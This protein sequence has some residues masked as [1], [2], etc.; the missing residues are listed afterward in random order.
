MTSVASFPCDAK[1]CLLHASR[2]YTCG[3]PAPLWNRRV[4]SVPWGNR[5]RQHVS[6]I[7]VF[8]TQNSSCVCPKGGSLLVY[9]KQPLLQIHMCGLHKLSTV[10]KLTKISLC[11]SCLT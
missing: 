8:E 9:E 10:F 4:H 6:S 1:V 7:V 3:V 11:G 2:R 5:G